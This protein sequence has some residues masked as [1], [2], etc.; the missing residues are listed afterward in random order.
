[1]AVQASGGH[2]STAPV[3]FGKMIQFLGI[4][5]LISTQQGWSIDDYWNY[6]TGE[7]PDQETCLCIY[8]MWAFMSVRR[9]KSINWYLTFMDVQDPRLW[10]SFWRSAS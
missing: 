3:T 9:F 1:V 8:N 2:G 7:L 5:L 4:K 10:T 6:S